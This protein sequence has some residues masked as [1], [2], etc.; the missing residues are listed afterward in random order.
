MNSWEVIP[1]AARSARLTARRRFFSAFWSLPGGEMEFVGDV[2]GEESG[3]MGGE[4]GEE[5]V[6]FTA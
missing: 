5:F 1:V 4:E 6:D 3:G 2:G